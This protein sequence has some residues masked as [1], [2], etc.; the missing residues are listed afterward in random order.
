MANTKSYHQSFAPHTVCCD[1]HPM[2]DIV[3]TDIG[4]YKLRLPVPFSKSLWWMCGTKLWPIVCIFDYVLN[5]DV[6]LGNKN[7]FIVIV[8][9]E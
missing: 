2:K 5:P 8:I 4:A 1:L 9:V 6:L 7:C 3:L